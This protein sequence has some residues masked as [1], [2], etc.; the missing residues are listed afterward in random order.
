METRRIEVL[1]ECTYKRTINVPADWD[2]DRITN[3]I[4]DRYDDEDFIDETP[5][6]VD[7]DWDYE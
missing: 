4:L 1:C 6:K 3:Y 2:K 5:I 7:L